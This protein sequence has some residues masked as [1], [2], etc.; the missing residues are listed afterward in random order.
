MR[1]SSLSDRIVYESS[2]LE[3]EFQIFVFPQQVSATR[4][5]SDNLKIFHFYKK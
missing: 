4:P 1:Q 5:I 3:L 2:E